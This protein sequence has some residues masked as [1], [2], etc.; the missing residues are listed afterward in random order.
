MSFFD[1]FEI[2]ALALALAFVIAKALYLRLARQ[3]AAIMIGR[4]R[5][6]AFIFEL[7]AVVGFTAWAV[8]I[9]L[10]AFHSRFDLVPAALRFVWFNSFALK[11]L[12]MVLVS[13]GLLLDLLA[14]VNFGDSWRVGIDNEKAGALVT[15]GVFA[16]TRNP[17]YVA[18]D[19]IFL[20]VFLINGTWIFLV[21]ALLAMFASH[22]QIIRE[23]RFLT[24]QDGSAC[25]YYFRRTP[26][27][28]IC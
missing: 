23:E 6:I 13:L 11:V 28:L 21:F 20:G 1:Y 17:I 25:I 5:S 14:L 15:D 27:H 12:G 19:L 2:A 16:L 9:L 3:T 8:E 10:C 18:F 22:Q 4:R 7:L 26:R 24:Q